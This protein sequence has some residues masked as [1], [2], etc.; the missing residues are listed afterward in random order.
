MSWAALAA[1]AVSLAAK[2]ISKGV[3]KH[4]QKKA[5][6]AT[7]RRENIAFD[8]G[9]RGSTEAFQANPV[10]ST[11]QM[12]AVTPGSFSPGEAE[13]IQKVFDPNQETYGSMF[14]QQS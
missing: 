9:L 13:K 8:Q 7:L 4:K 14:T 2:G 1:T 6:A 3:A 10:S 12:G 5:D 11:Q